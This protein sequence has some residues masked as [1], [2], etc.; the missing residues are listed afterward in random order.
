MAEPLPSH[1]MSEGDE[2]TVSEVTLQSHDTWG[3][4]APPVPAQLQL[5]DEVKFVV[6]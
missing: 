3:G 2:E 4:L 6:C 5:S 1:R